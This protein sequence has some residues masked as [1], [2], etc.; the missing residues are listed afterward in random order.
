MENQ[1][2]I[3]A[4][5][6][7]TLESQTQ[8]HIQDQR[9]NQARDCGIKHR[10]DVLDDVHPGYVG[11]H[12]CGVGERGELIAKNRAYYDSARGIGAGMP[13]PSATPINATPMVPIVPQEVPVI[14]DIKQHKMQLATKNMGAGRSFRP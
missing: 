1:L 6:I 4:L 13:S 2:V 14:R 11:S 10:F 9:D 12:D 8:K 7:A 5:D 3:F